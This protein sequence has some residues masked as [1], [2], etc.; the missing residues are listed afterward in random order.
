M[1]IDA[2]PWISRQTMIAL[3]AW[4]ACACASAQ[5]LTPATLPDNH[6]P[7]VGLH[8]ST[9]GYTYRPGEFVPFE[10][11]ASRGGYLSL[12]N[13]GSSGAVTRLL[14][15]VYSRDTFIRA[16]QGTRFGEIGQAYRFQAIG[17]DGFE[18]VLA[19]WTRRAQAQPDAASFRD[20]EAFSR[21]LA[22]LEPLPR[23]DWA[24]ARVTFEISS[25]APA[26]H[27][28]PLPRSLGSARV[29]LLAMG[30]NT[31][32]LTRANEDARMF[33]A[34]MGEVFGGA[35]RSR[36]VE[37]VT[38]DEFRDGMRWLAG[39][40]RPRD[41]VLV[42]F[43]GHGSFVSDDDGD[44]EDGLDEVFVTYDVE[45]GGPSSR[46]IVR[47][48]EFARWVGAIDSDELLV[49][50]DACYGA[51]L[52]RSLANMRTKYFRGGELGVRPE[53]PTAPDAP[54][55]HRLDPVKGL[56]YAA[57]REYE[58]AMETA[59]G[60]LFVR[61]FLEELGTPGV[62]HLHD[63]FERSRERVARRTGNRQN[64]AMAGNIDVARRIGLAPN[65]V[66]D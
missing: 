65:I 43:S 1:S 34:A 21:A 62:R 38:R 54:A 51:G 55:R 59:E 50:L 31:G 5:G 46:H 24:T 17:A 13:I 44:E 57:S 4:I 47:D 60:G 30:A 53:R 8:I 61:T 39:Q 45:L 63:V 52:S 9:P 56:V 2:L 23:G 15:N 48:D 40:V 22:A 42:F 27:A 28:A 6:Q 64:P 29:F 37:N 12:W 11:R 7:D 10:V 19:L 41:R 16:G 18:D 33:H 20:A 35:M 25:G 3:A 49:F 14:P 36:L 66:S 26:P 58:L 32:Q